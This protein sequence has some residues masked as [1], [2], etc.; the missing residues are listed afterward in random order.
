MDRILERFVDL[1]PYNTFGLPVVASYFKLISDISEME[2]LIVDT[3]FQE[4][5]KLILGGGSNLLF[6]DDFFDGLVIQ[7]ENQ[8]WEVLDEKGNLVFIKVQAGTVWSAF[9]D[10]MVDAGYHGLENLALIPGKVGAAPMQNIGAY[11]VEIKDCFYELEAFDFQT[12]KIEKFDKDSCDFGYRTSIFKHNA[13][14]R[15]LINT[16]T[17]ALKKQADLNTSYGN[18]GEYFTKYGIKNPD[19][20]ALSE[21]V[22]AIR[23]SKL[24]DPV[25]IGNAGSFF[26]NPVIHQL[27]FDDLLK[28]FP[29]VP[30]FP[31]GINTYKIPAAWLIE[32]AGWKGYRKGDAGVHDKQALVLVNYGNATGRE[33]FALAMKIQLDVKKKYGIYLDPEVKII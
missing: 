22:K 21:A 29:Q 7:L 10:A 18:L 1:K 25:L 23:R 27:L 28:E 5:R 19:I 8:G 16:V 9:V 11:G 32:H 24:P 13:R 12:G 30:A 3:V 14:G 33:I 31:A 20:K 4:S 6:L 15:Y 26:K 2:A 17:F